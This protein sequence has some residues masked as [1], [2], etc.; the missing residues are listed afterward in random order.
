MSGS[1][2]D[3]APRRCASPGSP[4]SVWTPRLVASLSAAASHRRTACS[5][6]AG[7]NWLRGGVLRLQAPEQRDQTELRRFAED[8]AELGAAF[9]AAQTPYLESY[10]G[11]AWPVDSVVAIASLRLHDFPSPAKYA[12][13]SDRWLRS[14]RERLDPRTGNCRPTACTRKPAHPRKSLA[15]RHKASS[16]ASCPKSTRTSVPSNICAFVSATWSRR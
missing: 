16:T 4:W 10:P 14:V 5:T 9:A 13:T 12:P 7:T 15:V 11:Q 1:V 2:P 6:A 8:S 3:I